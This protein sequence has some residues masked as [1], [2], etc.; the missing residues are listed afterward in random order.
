VDIDRD[1]MPDIVFYQ[2]GKV[3]T[4]FNQLK[5]KQFEANAFKEE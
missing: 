1:S 3:Y 4:F 2:E 5:A